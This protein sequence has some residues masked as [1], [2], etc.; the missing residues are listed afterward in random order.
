MICDISIE[1]YTRLKYGDLNETYQHDVLYS[2]NQFERDAMISAMNVICGNIE[3][4]CASAINSKLE[5]EKPG[6][7]YFSNDNA[8]AAKWSK[9]IAFHMT[10]V[11]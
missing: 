8:H 6:K 3:I 11:T 9:R 1:L 10:H 2:D 7:S 5:F 4:E